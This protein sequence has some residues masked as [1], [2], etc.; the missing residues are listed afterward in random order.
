[1]RGKKGES[2]LVLKDG[3]IVS[4]SHLNNSVRIGKVL[5]EMGVITEDA[6]EQALQEQHRAGTDRR[7][8]IVTLVE[9]GLAREEDAYRGLE[10]LIEMTIVEILR[11]KRGT[12][13]LEAKPSAVADQYRYYPD[14]I[15]REISV[16]TQGALM[17][18]LRIFDEKMRDG[19]LPEENEE[20]DE[21]PA[22]AGEAAATQPLSADDLGLGELDHIE[23]RPR[24]SFTSLSDVDPLH[25]QRSRIRELAADLT[26][27]G[28][29][30]LA[31]FLLSRPAEKLPTGNLPALIVCS[32]DELL[33]HCLTTLC[34]QT[35]M[36]VC[37]VR[38]SSMLAK[39]GERCAIL[40][41]VPIILF[42]A[43]DA[44]DSQFA[45]ERAEALAQL[46]SRKERSTPLIQL[47]APCNQELALKAYAQG[48]RAVLPRP[49]T[50]LATE[51]DVSRLTLFLG[52]VLPLLARCVLEQ[53][54]D[55][56]SR[57]KSGL[58]RL[59]E[60]PTPPAVATT[61]LQQVADLGNR[62][63]TLVVRGGELIAEKGIGATADRSAGIV[64]AP[65]FRIPLLEGSLL[66]KV[67][68]EGRTTSGALEE[69]LFKEHLF[70]VIGAPLLPI[71]ILLPIR[72]RGRTLAL[73]YGDFGQM[74]AC[75]VNGDLLDILAALAN[76][77]LDRG[78]R[79]A[80]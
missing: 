26:D 73:I 44:G 8:L 59:L 50:L 77:V 22:S 66:R 23:E 5:L 12:F 53:A 49:E 1:V 16:D 80:V 29:E 40:S 18:A 33:C 32:P 74:E 68:D 7:P 47:A 52:S 10:Q 76:L 21:A 28:V 56:L 17:E 63:L 31:A 78:S 19:L 46:Q 27:E 35:G 54:N 65:A 34:S 9:L 51:D 67:V 6:L 15:N 38:E 43:P 72:Y 11:W 71:G 14:R 4:A 48:F 39:V 36:F 61:L 37:T 42:D 3:Y 30:R 2:E 70:P 69:P 64:A 62:A 20:E 24:K 57:L 25:L 13:V 41:S 58:T 79:P 75:A 45:A 55:P 60:Q